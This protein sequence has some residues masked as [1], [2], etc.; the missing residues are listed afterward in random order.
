LN[1]ARIGLTGGIGSGKS[2]VAAMFAAWDVPVLDLD[3][4]GR[5]LTAQTQ[6]ARQIIQCFG[7]EVIGNDGELDRQALARRV[8]TDA[9]ALQQL[10]QL[11]HPLIWQQEMRW[12]DKV[13]ASFAVIEASVLIESGGASRM[14]SIIVVLAE[15]SIR[16]QRVA[17]RGYPD[18]RLFDAII[19]Q[20][21]DDARRMAV[22]DFII[23]NNGDLRALKLRVRD[24]YRALC[25]H[26]LLDSDRRSD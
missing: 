4:V 9:G 14:D 1:I 11:L 3:Q 7:D 17:A 25:R 5:E 19:R 16:R 18:I 8:F 2:T 26:Y 12:L 24:V 20:Q 10:N 21:V 15:E 6:V 22:A 13:D 23:E